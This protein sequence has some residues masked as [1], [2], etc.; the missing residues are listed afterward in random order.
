MSSLRITHKETIHVDFNYQFNQVN[1]WFL[2]VLWYLE[3]KISP[4]RI[5]H[6]LQRNTYMSISRLIVNW[7]KAFSIQHWHT[8]LSKHSLIALFRTRLSH[9][10]RAGNKYILWHIKLITSLSFVFTS[11]ARN[12]N[13]SS[14]FYWSQS[15][16]N[17]NLHID[18]LSASIQISTRNVDTL[19]AHSKTNLDWHCDDE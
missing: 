3:K 19:L 4:Y 16:V 11:Y 18:L 8:F 5:V 2:V 9:K 14:T 15:D 10:R 7:N 6:P 12:N 17:V 13:L 1:L